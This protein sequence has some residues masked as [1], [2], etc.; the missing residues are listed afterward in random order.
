LVVAE[1]A[2]SRVQASASGW[3]ESVISDQ[4]SLRVAVGRS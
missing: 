2:E 4:V 1:K 3:P